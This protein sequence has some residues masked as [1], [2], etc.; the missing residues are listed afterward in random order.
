MSEDAAGERT[1]VG[2]AAT[3]AAR[4]EAK[5][6]TGIA[7]TTRSRARET[8]GAGAAAAATAAEAA[9][10]TDVAAVA[11]AAAKAEAA[12]TPPSPPAD[13]MTLPGLLA[14]AAEEFGDRVFLRVGEVTRTYRESR[15][16]AATMAGAL[17]ARGCGPGDRIAV[18]AGNRIEHV[19]LILG[20]AWLGAVL[21]PLNTGLR[22]QGLRDVLRTAE[23]AFLLADA[24]S[25]AR[26][27]DAGYRG[28]LWVLGEEDVPVPGGAPALPPA[29]VRPDDTA[30][31]LFT[32]GTTGT[33][34]GVRCPHAQSVWWG[35]NVADALHLTADDVL[36]TCLPLF[37]TNALNALAQAMTVGATY[38]LAP[39]FSATRY[40]TQ[41]AD[42]GATV[43]YLLGAMA[44]MLLAQPPGLHERA[45]R[46]RCGLSPATPGP[47][48]QPFHERFG[49]TLVD[50]F[51]STETNLVIGSTPEEQRP[52]YIGTVRDGFSARVVD[53][54][55]APVPDGTAGELLVHS[56][57]AFAFSTGYLG[58]AENLP[59]ASWRRTGDRVVREPDGWFLF[60]DRLK[61]VIR[62][63]GENIS[64]QEVESVLRAHPAVADAAAFPVPSELAED[65]VMVA[66]L[67]SSE[68]GLDPREL[69]RHCEREL[70][71]FAVPRYIETVAELPLTE[72]GKVR[73]AVLRER[74]I[75]ATTWD[76]EA[77][78]PPSGSGVN[79][80]RPTPG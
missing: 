41:V 35:R 18:M 54:C 78:A 73:K 40:W 21:V 60:V 4:D 37:H 64:S 14:F 56:H 33:S 13:A 71:A 76:R 45:H 5:S 2:S 6:G 25:A 80:S 55:L 46:V 68:R 19:D 39:R 62:R 27:T 38:V 52:G 70:P 53:E 48:W 3:A 42:A 17:A 34:R 26:V 22:G 69:V 30:F 57:Q 16:A 29:P 63:R 66:V 11:A 74:G 65:E 1:G 32:S 12:A 58:D 23:P 47:A 51:G 72:T 15:E 44:P 61:D 43:V 75:T 24:E 20:G 9:A 67:P 79:P 36:H 50:G 7:G 28:T 10:A 31:V 8:P 49:V 77:G 59:P